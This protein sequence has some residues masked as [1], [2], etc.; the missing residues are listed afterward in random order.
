MIQ[1]WLFENDGTLHHASPPPNWALIDQNDAVEVRVEP[2]VVPD[3][4]EGFEVMMTGDL[5]EEVFGPIRGED[6]AIDDPGGE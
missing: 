4:F 6:A 2:G 5:G 3:G 1:Y